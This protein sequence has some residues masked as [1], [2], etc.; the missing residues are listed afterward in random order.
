M[1]NDQKVEKVKEKFCYK[2]CLK[3]YSLKKW[4][5]KHCNVCKGEKKEK[6]V[7]K[8]EKEPYIPDDI[9]FNI[10][11]QIDELKDLIR[12]CSYNKRMHYFYKTNQEY[13]SS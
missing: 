1:S 11:Y 3:E 12:Y 6:V 5:D 2:L 13:I 9:I 4:Y 10:I 8:K 7:E